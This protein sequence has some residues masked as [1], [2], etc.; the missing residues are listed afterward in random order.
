MSYYRHH[1]FFCTNQ[2]EGGDVCC[3][4]HNAT[5]MFFYAK[6]YAQT[7]GLDDVR[8][9]RT[10]CLGRCDLGPVAV[11]YPQNVWYNYIDESD[12][13]EIVREHLQNDRVVER[14]MV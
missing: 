5:D 9:N 14:L 10:G 11:V 3:N 7:L 2:R 1:L 4:S 6:D 8:I 13:E 12:V